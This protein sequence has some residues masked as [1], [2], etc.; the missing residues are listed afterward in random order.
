MSGIAATLAD[1][2]ALADDLIAS[3]QAGEKLKAFVE[4]T[5]MMRDLK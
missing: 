1:G 5:Q 3:G 4:F 2:V